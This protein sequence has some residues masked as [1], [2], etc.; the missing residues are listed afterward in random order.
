[1]TPLRSLK[2]VL[3]DLAALF[4]PRSS[5]LWFLLLTASL[6]QLGF[7]YMATP[8]PTLLRFAPRGLPTAVNA[9]MW[10]L[11]FLVLVPGLF[12]G[13]FGMRLRDVGVRLGNTSFGF[14]AALATAV[15]ALPFIFLASGD[16]S[17]QA[18]YPWAGAWVGSSLLTLA[19][20]VVL[21]ALYYFAFEFFY[22]GFLLHVV[23]DAWGT[24]AALWVQTLAAGLVHLGKPMPEAIAAIPASLL[25][26]VM[27]VRGRSILY[28]MLLH[29]AIGV[30]T[31]VFVLGRL[32]LLL[33]R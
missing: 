21:Y 26:G 13:L 30:A 31:D 32:G 5:R 3:D 6:V 19:G 23:Q 8:G 29:L 12:M 16:A 11:V 28:P 33:P 24:T 27:A 17:L 2:V 7:W 15:I 4:T 20:W 9:I 22:R 10:S 1:M 14:P 25:F 18:T